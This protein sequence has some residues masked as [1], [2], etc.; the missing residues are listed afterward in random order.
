[1]S[2]LKIL[3]LTRYGNLGASSRLRF[4]QYFPT[5]RAAG[6]EITQQA[7]FD[8]A[9]L[10]RRYQQGGYGL[11]VL[12]RCYVARIAAL[13]NAR[14]FDLL[15][16]EKEALPWLPAWLEIWLFR[17][18]PFVLDFDDAVFHNYDQHRLSVVRCIYSMRLDKLMAKAACVVAGNGYLAQRAYE[19]GAQAVELVPTVIDLERYAVGSHGHA[20]VADNV[21]RVVWIGAPS[22]ARYVSLIADALKELAKRHVFE[23]HVIGGAVQID[24][25]NVQMV[26]WSEAT[27]VESIAACDIGV[28][29]LPDSPF[30]RGK[31]GY[32]L[33]QYMACG[34]PV[35]ASPV[36]VNE[37]IV[38]PGQNGFLADSKEQWVAALAQL[39][40]HADLRVKMGQQGRGF[41]EAQYCLQVTAPVTATILKTAALRA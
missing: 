17:N 37:E 29:P 33:I 38:R 40:S 5:L 4:F 7:F 9:A 26:T 35:V 8:D 15:W 22:T 20:S 27:E 19:A 13:L 31:C 10:N 25:V 32:K 18:V 23:L 30:E 2:T 12:L 16:I 36:G 24:G 6:L 28:M 3:A 21:L 1:M 39:L 11:L 14:Q 34:L 41:V